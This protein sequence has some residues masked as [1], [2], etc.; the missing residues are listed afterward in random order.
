MNLHAYSKNVFS[1]KLKKVQYKCQIYETETVISGMELHK[2]IT[3]S[4]YKGVL[5]AEPP[6]DYSKEVL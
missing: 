3:T 2:N 4:G 5:L 1:Q 6:V